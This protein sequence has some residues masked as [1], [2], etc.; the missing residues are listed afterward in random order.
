MVEDRRSFNFLVGAQF[1][2]AF[3]DN[4]FKQLILFLAADYLFPGKDVQGVA[5]AVFALPFV[6]FSGIAGD[7]SERYSKQTIILYMKIAE[8]AVMFLGALAL[9]SLNWPFLLVVLFLMGVHS[10][11]FG[12][13]KYGVIPELMPP[14]RLIQA[15]GIIAMTTFMSILLGQALAGPLIDGFVGRFWLPGLFCIGFAVLGTV[16]AKGMAPLAAQK[17]ALPLPRSPLGN[18]RQT[19]VELRRR[20]GLFSLVVLHSYF[21]FNGGVIQQSI[22]GMGEPDC[23]A[24]G[25]GEKH[26]LSYLLITLAISIIIGSVAAPRLGKKLSAGRMTTVGASN[27]AVGQ[28]ALL[29][30]GPI[31]DRTHYAFFATHVIL[32]WIGFSGAFFVVSIQSFLQHAPPPG[33]KGQTFAVNNFMN[34][35]FI[36][37]GGLYYLFARQP[38]PGLG[39]GPTV[40]QA[41]SAIGMLA[42]L[43]INRRWLSQM[44]ISKSETSG[45]D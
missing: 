19:M 37:F 20:Q 9:Q 25:E 23:L 42:M 18:L 34:F 45:D 22:L 27:M 8:V 10:A 4:L 12:P 33:T 24:V 3:N 41:I 5:F 2:G 40:T 13:S 43:W 7:L 36:F 28:I 16:F 39:L 11:F 6:L 44:V 29:L 17:P 21:W 31:L 35:L 30:I 1:L 15:N 26:L 14:H 38:T 32:A